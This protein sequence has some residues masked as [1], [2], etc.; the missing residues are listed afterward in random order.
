LKNNILSRYNIAS[1]ETTKKY[2]QSRAKSAMRAF[3]PFA[4][5]FNILT[6]PTV[7]SHSNATRSSSFFG[8]YLIVLT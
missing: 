1:S 8:Y 6:L 7:F 2:P 5:V 3:Y 4:I